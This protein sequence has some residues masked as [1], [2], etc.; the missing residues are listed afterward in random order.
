MRKLLFFAFLFWATNLVAATYYVSPTGSDSANGSSSTPWRTIQHAINTAVAGDTV[1][2]EN[3]TYV[4]AINFTGSGTSGSPITFQAQNK[5]GAVIAPTAT[6]VGNNLGDV[7]VMG[8]KYVNL[9]NFEIVGP[10]D[11]SASNG[12]KSFNNSSGNDLIKGNKIHDIGLV[13]CNG[14]AGILSGGNNNTID[15]NLVYHIG[16]P[17]SYNCSDW[18]TVYL[19][20]GNGQTVTNNLVGA[21][22]GQYITGIQ[23]NGEQATVATFPSNITVANNTVFNVSAGGIVWSCWNIPAAHTCSNNITSNNILYNVNSGG[24]NHTIAAPDGNGGTW[25]SNNIYSNNDIYCCGTPNMGSTQMLT[26]TLTSNPLFVNYTGDQN[27]D[28]HLQSTSAAI[29]AGTSVGAPNYDYDGNTR[30]QGAGY[31]I[32][33]YEY[34][35]TKPNPPTGLTATVQ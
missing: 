5:W 9:L 27:G 6:Q 10:S 2:V 15:S 14:G 4:E 32:G 33:T 11:G 30:P 22:N 21:A 19:N 17:S 35:A 3:G 28:Y 24:N 23:I 8:G 29:D 18:D 34:G 20:D 7:I 26:N 25:S 13:G 1:T 31:D 16:A 12:I